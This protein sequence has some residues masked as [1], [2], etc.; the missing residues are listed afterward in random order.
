MRKIVLTI[1]LLSIILAGCSFSEERT[2]KKIEKQ[3]NKCEGYESLLDIEVIMDRNK[4]L[5]KMKEK[6]KKD[7]KTIVKIIYPDKNDEIIL[8]Y[9]EDK[10]IINNTIIEQ[11]ITLNDFKDLNKGFLVKDIVTDLKKLKFI[12]EKKIDDKKYFAFDYPIEDKNKY[13]HKKI[14]LFDKKELIPFSLEILDSEGVTRTNIFYNNF[15]F[16]P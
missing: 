4:S 3:F 10:I 5:Y 12:E 8:E 2:V 9:L 16:L 11:S 7:G 15:K 13:N 14:I 1:F 6:H